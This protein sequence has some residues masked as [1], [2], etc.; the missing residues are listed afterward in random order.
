ML[1]VSVK[2]IQRG[3]Q[4]G[5]EG[6]QRQGEPYKQLELQLQQAQSLQQAALDKAKS[7]N[8]LALEKSRTK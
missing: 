1:S 7:E 2:K 6:Y 3:K 8:A 5:T 4:Q